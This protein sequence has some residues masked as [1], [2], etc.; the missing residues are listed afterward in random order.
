MGVGEDGLEVALKPSLSDDHIAGAEIVTGAAT[1]FTDGD[2]GDAAVGDDHIFSHLGPPE[3]DIRMPKASAIDRFDEA[4][5]F[6]ARQVKAGKGI[7][8]WT[9]EILERHTKSG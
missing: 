8:G 7:A 3:P 5:P 2:T 6:A 4:Q 1:Q 9:F